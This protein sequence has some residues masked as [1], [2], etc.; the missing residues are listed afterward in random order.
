M[1]VLGQGALTILIVTS[2][3]S[4]AMPTGLGGDPAH[5]P[6]RVLVIVAVWPA[7][8]LGL[9]L[10]GW[11]ASKRLLKGGHSPIA[12]DWERRLL[13]SRVIGTFG[14]GLLFIAAGVHG[15]VIGPTQ[16][17]PASAELAAA[18]LIWLGFW[19]ERRV[20]RE[21]LGMRRPRASL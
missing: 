8:M 17:H 20:V 16:S 13:F 21:V 2:A 3:W 18:I 10:I 12:T 4:L 15:A 14:L 19:I 5:P 11:P 7:A 9:V 6:A 1:G